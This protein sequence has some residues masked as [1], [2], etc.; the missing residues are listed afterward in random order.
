ML[1]K[2]I[3]GGQTSAHRVRMFRQI[4]KIALILS[5][6]SG[7][8]FFC[9]KILDEP[10]RNFSALYHL[11]RCN[12]SRKDYIS[13]E[14]ETWKKLSG[15]DKETLYERLKAF[16]R[17][18]KKGKLRVVEK[19]RAVRLLTCRTTNL[20]RKAFH[21]FRHAVFVF[22]GSFSFIFFLFYQFG[23]QIKKKKLI[24]GKPVKKRRFPKFYTKG[25]LRLGKAALLKKA[26]THHMLITGGTGSGKTNAIHHLLPQIRKRGQKVIIVDTTSRFIGSYYDSKKDFILNPFDARTEEWHPWADCKESYDFEEIS[27]AFIHMTGSEQDPFWENFSAHGA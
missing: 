5:F 25:G 4:F 3:S 20:K 21:H 17:S 11:V 12:F 7:G 10:F 23:R 9:K 6:A 13:F 8:T 24:S 19:K 2:I 26:E 16:K 1:K 18:K 27:S 15:V 14:E 22:V